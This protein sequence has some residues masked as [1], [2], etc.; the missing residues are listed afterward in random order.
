MASLSE[1]TLFADVP[2]LW[3]ASTCEA[4][5]ARHVMS[6]ET[7]QCL[8]CVGS[9]LCMHYSGYVCTA[10]VLVILPSCFHYRASLCLPSL[11]LLH[12]YQE[13]E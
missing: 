3:F 4:L 11:F 6:A 2:A 1:V 5:Y 9:V 8:S 7:M 12:L 13:Q 10:D